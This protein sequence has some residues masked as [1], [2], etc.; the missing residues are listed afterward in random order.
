MNGK[1]LQIT[2]R[3][4]QRHFSD[5][6]ILVGL[7]VVGALLGITGPFGTFASLET[8]PRLAYWLA[9]AVGTYGT[10]ML[11]SLFIINAFG[12]T[13]RAAWARVLVFGTITG[14]PVT[15]VVLLLN[16]VTFGAGWRH[17]ID[18]M[19]LWLDS[20]LVG[21]GVMAI[22]EI[23][24]GSLRRPTETEAAANAAAPSSPAILERVPLPQ[25][26][27]LWALIVQDHYV[28][29]LTERGRT[30]VLMRLSDAI[31]ETAGVRGLQIHRSH[32]VALE[33]VRRVVREDG[34]PAAELPDGR[35]LGISRS[36]LAAAREAGLV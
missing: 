9:V 14:V 33:A 2:L 29:V 13:I 20:T 22:S 25:R 23:L 24:G 19:T 34:K 36:Y 5:P 8:V 28:E 21:F 31:R 7:V 18:P 4:M 12:M 15:L 10:G 35:R 26:G 30:L 32:W 3:E 27:A 17:A 11:V 6:R 16:M 1:A